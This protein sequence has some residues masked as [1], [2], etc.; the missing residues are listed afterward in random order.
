MFLRRFTY[1]V[2]WKMKLKILPNLIIEGLRVWEIDLLNVLQLIN[3]MSYKLILVEI[4][5]H[6][7]KYLG[8][9]KNLIWFCFLSRFSPLYFLALILTP[10][11]TFLYFIYSLLE[12]QVCTPDNFSSMILFLLLWA[13]SF[14][15]LHKI[16]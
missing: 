16:V 5:D 4:C 13:F 11:D 12:F 2:G 15:T 3:L 1:W 10:K 9:K 8:D 6:S 7:N 14:Y